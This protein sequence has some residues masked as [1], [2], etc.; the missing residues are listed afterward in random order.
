MRLSLRRLAAHWKLKLAALALSI[1]LWVV[2]SSEQVTTQW[3]DVRV[4]PV[5]RAPGFAL[6]GR[7]DPQL[8]RV[9][10]RGAGRELWRLALRPPTLVLPVREMGAAF[11]VEAA[12]VDVPESFRGV[13]ALDVRP[14]VVRLDLE[15][16]STRIVPVRPVVSPRALD[17][18]V[19][20]DSLVVIPRMVRITGPEEALAHI[21]AIPTRPFDINPDDS[22]FSVRAV[23]DTADLGG[24]SLSVG[25]VRVRGRA[26]ARVERAFAAVA[27]TVPGGM[28]ATPP[29]VEVR[30]A[31]AARVVNP[32]APTEVRAA[33]RRDSLPSILPP[34]GVEAA[35]SV[36]GIPAG[37][38]VR[39]MP[40][41]IRITPAVLA[42]PA[43]APPPAGAPA[44][45]APR[46]PA[47]APPDTSAVPR[48]R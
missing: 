13:T 40:P 12:M 30:V 6:T 36:D 37:A 35:V 9:R 29:V 42:P 47:P 43:A 10:F 3:I 11:A 17:R 18:V 31:G 8:V 39:V 26:D 22:V 23:L 1:L 33:V 25:E 2:F 4:D 28:A 14:G 24:A 7:P 16:V 46:P 5:V 38:S 34:G 15:R 44:S 21:D 19:L 41:R 32:L 27:V 45:P 20:G 48:P